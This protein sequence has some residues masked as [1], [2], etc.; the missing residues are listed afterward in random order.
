M[1]IFL[2]RGIIAL[3]K[4]KKSQWS[5]GSLLILLLCFSGPVSDGLAILTVVHWKSSLLRTLF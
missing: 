3:L 5:I 4:A 2:E 1:S